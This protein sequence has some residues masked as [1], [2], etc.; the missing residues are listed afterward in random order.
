MRRS[1]DLFEVAA[2]AFKVIVAQIACRHLN[3][4]MVECGILA[5]VE[6][7]QMELHRELL[8]QR[9]AEI[10][11]AKRLLATQQ[12]VAMYRFNPISQFLERQQ[13]SHTIGSAGKCNEIERIAVHATL[14]C[15]KLRN[16]GEKGFRV[17]HKGC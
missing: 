1:A 3:A 14:V 11:I 5:S 9:S 8:A 7:H 16:G 10:L 13:Q 15:G 4:L 6:M 12:K 2:Q 17:V